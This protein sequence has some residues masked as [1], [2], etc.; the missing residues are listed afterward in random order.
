MQ[1]DGSQTFFRKAVKSVVA[2]F[3]LAP[4]FQG[5]KNHIIFVNPAVAVFVIGCQLL[6]AV[7]VF[8]S[9]ELAAV[10]NDTVPV[11]IQRQITAAV[12]QTGNQLFFAVAIQIKIKLLVGKLCCVAVKI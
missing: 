7:A 1:T 12:S 4:D 6:K 5:I 11:F 2:V 10:I 9:K 3:I 8:R